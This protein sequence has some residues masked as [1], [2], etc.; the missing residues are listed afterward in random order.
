MVVRLGLWF[1]F[2]YQVHFEK[3]TR[4]FMR[5]S[6]FLRIKRSIWQL[7]QAGFLATLIAFPANT[8]CLPPILLHFHW[9]RIKNGSFRAELPTT[10]QFKFL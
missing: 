5:S 6:V 10:G 4:M 1:P 7:E 3:A 9:L 8:Q 2:L